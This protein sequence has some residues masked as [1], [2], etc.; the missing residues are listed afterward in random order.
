MMRARPYLLTR[1]VVP[2]NQE[3]PIWFLRRSWL[4]PEQYV[5]RRNHFPYP[6]RLPDRVRV[7]IK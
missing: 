5:F 3:S 7:Q 4:V 6:S 1:S 2:E